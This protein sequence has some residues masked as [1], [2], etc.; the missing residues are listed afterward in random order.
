MPH[1]LWE[2]QGFKKPVYRY[3]VTSSGHVENSFDSEA[4]AEAWIREHGGDAEMKIQRV[5]DR[6]ETAQAGKLDDTEYDKVIRDIVTFMAYMAEPVKLERQ[7]LGIFVLL[8]LAVLFVSAY[9][10]KKE[11]WKDVH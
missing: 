6:L 9:L 5:V 3:D 2:L 10:L 7:R 11:Y 8:F 4:G 1:V